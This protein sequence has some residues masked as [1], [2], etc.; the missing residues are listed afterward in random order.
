MAISY[1]QNQLPPITHPTAVVWGE[2][3]PI[4]LSSWADRLQE[5][6]P[7]LV[8]LQL[9]ADIGHFVPFE[10]PDAFVEAIRTVL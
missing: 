8:H 2:A 5:Y 1:P 9:L 3:D 6:F 10:A 7:N 4:L